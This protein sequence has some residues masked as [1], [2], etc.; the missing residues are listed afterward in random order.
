MDDLKSFAKNDSEL[1]I[2]L[3]TVQMFSDDVGLSF[4]LDKC[5]KVLVSRGKISGKGYILLDGES[6]IDELN[7]GETYKY[8]GFH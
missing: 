1:E 3:C 4:G 8:L 2:L 6:N 7:V 5:A